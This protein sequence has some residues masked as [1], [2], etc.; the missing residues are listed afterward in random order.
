L[1]DAKVSHNW[2]NNIVII[3]GIGIVRTIP[4]IKKLGGQTKR[5]EILMCYDFHSGISYEEEDVMFAIKLDLFSIGTI[6]IPTHIEL[7]FK[8]AYIPNLSISKLVPKQPIEP[9]CVLI[10]NLA[11]PP[12]IVTPT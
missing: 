4:I 11:I 7:V 12:N 1:R 2:G 8:L 6:I 9:I 5:P 10:I 3:Q